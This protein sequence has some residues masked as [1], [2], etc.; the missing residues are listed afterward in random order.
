MSPA[1]SMEADKHFHPAKHFYPA[2]TDT[3]KHVR[4]HAFMCTQELEAR[5][6]EER[7]AMA[8]E[9][10]AHAEALASSRAADASAAGAA[11]LAQV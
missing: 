6:N 1:A 4:A 10:A 11:A 3:E 5:I 9:A 2:S 7:A 8:D